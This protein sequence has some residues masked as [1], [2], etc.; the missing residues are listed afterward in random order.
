VVESE[1]LG[2]MVCVSAGAFVMGS[3]PS[4]SG[5]YADEFQRRVNLANGICAMETEVSLLQFETVMGRNTKKQRKACG[6]HCPV[7]GVSWQDAVRFANAASKQAGLAPAYA[8]SGSNVTWKAD[9]DGC[10]RCG[11]GGGVHRRGGAGTDAAAE[12]VGGPRRW[13]GAV[14]AGGEAGWAGWGRGL[15]AW[16]WAWAA[17]PSS[18]SGAASPWPGWAAARGRGAR[19][20]RLRRWHA[21]RRASVAALAAGSLSDGDGGGLA[22]RLPYLGGWTAG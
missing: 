18:A 21:P 11:L 20:A 6:D 3:P 7:E 19:G 2:P 13:C 4:E 8:I 14:T 10:H 17:V 5:R 9:A 12:L 16:A 1:A 22:R 15:W